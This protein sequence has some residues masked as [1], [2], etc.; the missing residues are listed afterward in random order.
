[1]RPHYLKLDRHLI[2]GIDTDPD[3]GALVSAMYATAT[4]AHTAGI[5]QLQIA[6]SQAQ[7]EHRVLTD[8]SDVLERRAPAV[9]AAIHAAP[10]LSSFPESLDPSPWPDTHRFRSASA[11]HTPLPDWWA[12]NASPL[13]YVTFGSV[14]GGLPEAPAAYLQAVDGLPV[15]VLLTVGSAIDLDLLGPTPA[16]THVERWVPQEDVV[17]SAALVVCHGGSGTVFGALAAGLPLVVCPLF[18]DQTANGWLIQRAGASLVVTAPLPAA[19]AMGQLGPQQAGRLREAIVTMLAAP[20]PRTAARR[21]AAEVAVAPTLDA[22][23]GGLLAHVS[24]GARGD[25]RPP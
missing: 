16:N 6:I 3:R 24:A 1:V 23:L 12:G 4:V 18:P 15:R 22:V 2:S 7:I 11:I 25:R 5:P 10:F 19:G 14:L 21:I 13:V 8:V 20:G 9:T 17:A